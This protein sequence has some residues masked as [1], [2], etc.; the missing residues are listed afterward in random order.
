MSASLQP[1]GSGALTGAA[2]PVTLTFAKVAVDEVPLLWLVTASPI[3]AEP[4]GKATAEPICVQVVP[5]DD[6]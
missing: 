5:L 2:S 1:E 4:V 3:K 6:W